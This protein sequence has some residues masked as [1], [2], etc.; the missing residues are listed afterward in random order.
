MHIKISPQEY[1]ELKRAAAEARRP[2][3]RWLIEVIK[4]AALSLESDIHAA[5]VVS[6]PHEAETVAHSPHS[7]VVASKAPKRIAAGKNGWPADPEA[8]SAEMRRRMAVA[9]GEAPT[10]QDGIYRDSNG[11][12]IKDRALSEH[13]K[14]LWAKMTVKQRKERLAKMAAG[15]VKAA[16]TAAKVPVVKVE[17]AA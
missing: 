4:T 5:E 6:S 7:T 2:G 15:K 12:M 14:K 1:H 3:V 16:K 17:S 9:R 8:R 10:K 13:R 11:H